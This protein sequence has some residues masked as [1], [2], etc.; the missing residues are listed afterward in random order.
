MNALQ[1]DVA[2]DAWAREDA[3]DRLEDLENML[4]M[5]ELMERNRTD[6]STKF[7]GV[8]KVGMHERDSNLAP[9][10]KHL[11]S[12]FEYTA[13]HFV[14]FVR[15]MIDLPMPFLGVYC[16]HPGA[17]KRREGRAKGVD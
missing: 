8:L 13:H 11:G 9:A 3:S 4:D 15:C 5:M 2:V 6:T 12:C 16:Y 7:T 1:L 14:A 10:G 17:A